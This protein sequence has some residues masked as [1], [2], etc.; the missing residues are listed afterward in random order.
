MPLTFAAVSQ[1]PVLDDESAW[2]AERRLVPAYRG[3]PRGERDGRRSGDRQHARQDG[4]RHRRQPAHRHLPGVPRPRHRGA[5]HE[6]GHV[7]APRHGREPARA[8]RA[9]GGG[10]AHRGGRAGLRR[11][12][13]RPH[14]LARTRSV[15]P[16]GAPSPPRRGAARRQEGRRHGGWHPR[17]HRR[18]ALH[19]QPLQRQDGPRGRRRGLPARRPRG[20]GHH[21]AGRRRAVRRRARGERRRHG[22]GR[23]RAGPRRGRARH[24]RR[25]RRFQAA[26]PRRPARS[27]AAT[28]RPSR[29]SSCAP[30]TSSPRPPRPGLFRVGFAAE[31]GPQLRRARE[32]KAA[33]GVDL[34]VFNDI[35]AEGV[36]IGA[37]ENEITIITA[38]DGDR[39]CRAPARAPARPPS[40]TRS[41]GA[42][43]R[44]ERAVAR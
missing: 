29:S 35:L 17:A 8:G 13:L 27:R 39:T 23:P 21:A 11:G 44:D 18:G 6:L 5:H 19:R 22:G 34:L 14:G 40:P 12:G 26:P 24:G 37:D 42:A 15:W 9:R 32:K 20:A 2:Q 36:G 30:S 7:R 25:G 1:A 16:C 38:R 33:K 31:A 4:R 28:A 3:G 10:A 43:G 41:S